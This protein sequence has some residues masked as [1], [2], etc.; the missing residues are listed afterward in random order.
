MMMV[1]EI[2]FRHGPETERGAGQTRDIQ[3]GLD[4]YHGGSA[5]A[6]HL[7]A[8]DVFAR[9]VHCDTQNLGGGEADIVIL[10]ANVKYPGRLCI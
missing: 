9:P 10:N 8:T 6:L 7:T 4:L 2:R 5:L 1:E 3:G